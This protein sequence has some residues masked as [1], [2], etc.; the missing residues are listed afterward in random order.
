[1]KSKCSGVCRR[2]A[3]I[4]V[5]PGEQGLPSNLVLQGGHDDGDHNREG[6]D[7]HGQMEMV[8]MMMMVIMI[9]K[10]MMLMITDGDCD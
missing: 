4:R 8:V 9:M 2:S 3:T 7:D 5:Y 6:N 10:S 1:M